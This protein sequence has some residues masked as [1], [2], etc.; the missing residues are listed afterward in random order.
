MMIDDL[1]RNVS[2]GK[3]T[4]VILF[5]FSK[6]FY[7]VTHSKFLWKLHQYGIRGK[8]LSWLQAFWGNR[9]QRVVINGE[10]SDSIP[11]NSDVPQGSVLDRFFSLHI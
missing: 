4:Y 3:Q 5:D 9:S 1:A 11:V 7:K 8:V 10:E 6:A 2:A